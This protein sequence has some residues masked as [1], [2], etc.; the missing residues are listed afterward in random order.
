MLRWH[1]RRV[2]FNNSV[3]ITGSHLIFF[4][5]SSFLKSF[6][7]PFSF[8]N[9]VTVDCLNEWMVVLF[10][11]KLADDAFSLRISYRVV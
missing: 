7:L 1:Y 8:Y 10:V 9:V 5:I 2:P 11:L 6:K 4:R 3:V